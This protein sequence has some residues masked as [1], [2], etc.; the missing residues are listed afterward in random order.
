MFYFARDNDVAKVK[1]FESEVR[2]SIQEQVLF[3]DDFSKVNLDSKGAF[4]PNH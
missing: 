1:F 3:K 4:E 2:N